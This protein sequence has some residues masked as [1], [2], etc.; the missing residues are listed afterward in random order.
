MNTTKQT[1]EDFVKSYLITAL[2]AS[3]NDNGENNPPP[4]DQ[5][6]DL[7]DIA[8]ITQLKAKNDCQDFLKV[9][10]MACPS[11]ELLEEF[12]TLDYDSIGH[13]FFLTRNHHGAGFWD[14]DYSQELG[15]YL[16]DVSHKFGEVNFYVGDDNKIYSE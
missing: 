2:W 10:E 4:L 8:S 14:G 5:N 3:T 9:A 13:D 7:E 1:I 6:F 16:T 11:S 12:Y 15:K